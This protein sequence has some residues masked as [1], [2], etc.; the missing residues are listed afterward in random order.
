MTEAAISGAEEFYR[1]R[2]FGRPIGFGERPGIVVVDFINGFT[3]PALPYGA[4]LDEEI[5]A[6]GRL[7]DAARAS[8]DVPI[9]FIVTAYEFDDFRDA[10]LWKVK[11]AG[12][13]S[14]RAGTNAVEIDPR[15]GW[16]PNDEHRI[17]K[18]FASAFFG[19]DL[20][21][22]LNATS[23]DT[24]LLAGCATSGC[25]R[26]TAVDGL[27]NGYRVLVVKEAVGD[28]DRTAHERSLIEMDAKYADVISLDQAVT[29]LA[30]LHDHS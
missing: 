3:D 24:I 12:I 17:A 14:L 8:Q 29:Y 13:T 27:Q 1:S 28:R 22:R 18:K 26:A 21:S 20:V 2:G 7:L 4:V 11:Q 15:M 10:G 25:V 23:V 6:T 5:N 9:V 30:R 16:R 19:T